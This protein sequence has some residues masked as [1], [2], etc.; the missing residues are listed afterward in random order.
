MQTTEQRTADSS[1]DKT[2]RCQH[3]ENQTDA[4]P[5]ARATSTHFVCLDLAFIVH[6]QDADGA[7]LDLIAGLV[8][9]RYLLHRC[10]GCRFVVEH[11]K[12]DLLVTHLLTSLIVLGEP[13]GGIALEPRTAPFSL[14]ERP[15]PRESRK[16]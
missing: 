10:I 3:H 11:R 9:A 12:H 15:H 16:S 14:N 2:N 6:H 8:P 1:R 7:D 13:S 4:G 5:L